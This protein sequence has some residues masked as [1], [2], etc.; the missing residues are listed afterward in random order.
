MSQVQKKLLCILT[1]SIAIY[2]T[3]ETIRHLRAG[4]Y[5]VTCVL[6][7]AAQA[8]ITPLGVAAITGNPVYT[9]MFSPHDEA[10]MGHITLSRMADLVVVMP[11]SADILAKMAHGHADD[12]AST[13]LLATNKPV[14]VVPSMNV[15]MWEHKATKRNV[16]L[17]TDDGIHF[18][19]PASGSL[20]CGEEG[21]GRMAEAH[22]I[23][24]TITRLVS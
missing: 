7:K 24:A 11:A 23:I 16:K 6:T 3:M 13:L 12:L 5:E 10:T 4:D 15:M 14:L 17:L 22:D 18:V 21:T 1:G 19:G 20:A 8:F 9:D 2:K